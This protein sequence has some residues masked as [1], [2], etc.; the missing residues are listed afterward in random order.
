MLLT[1]YQGVHEK[2]PWLNWAEVIL[3]E[4][5]VRIPGVGVDVTGVLELD[6]ISQSDV[7]PRH[8]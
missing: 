4:V 6:N 5:T 7:A 8:G 3:P 2:F 1:F